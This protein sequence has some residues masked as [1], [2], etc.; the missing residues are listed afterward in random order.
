[1]FSFLRSKGIGKVRFSIIFVAIAEFCAS[2]S[3][4][5]LRTVSVVPVPVP[6]LV[7]AAVALLVVAVTLLFVRIFVLVLAVVVVC[8]CTWCC[9]CT[10]AVCR[11]ASGSLDGAGSHT[12]IY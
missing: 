3:H 9:F 11:G 5:L 10:W 4:T 1:M 8:C 2:Y 6:V 12:L 7:L